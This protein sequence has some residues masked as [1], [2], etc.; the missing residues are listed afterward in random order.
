MHRIQALIDADKAVLKG[1]DW[2]METPMNCAI[3][4]G[5]RDLVVLLLKN[6]ANINQAGPTGFAPLH[7]A[8]QLGDK[9]M[10]EFLL[11]SGAK[12]NVKTDEGLTPLH[13]AVNSR[14][15]GVVEILV[16]RGADLSVK[17]RFFDSIPREVDRYTPLQRAIKIHAEDVADFL[18]THGAKE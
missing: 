3:R 17:G 15:K 18:R 2:L 11:E 10:I 13:F 9:A 1:T 14:H 6:G 12:I 7:C 16:L 5:R 8:A 4:I